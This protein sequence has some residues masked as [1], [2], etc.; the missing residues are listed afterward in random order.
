MN[1]NIKK[2]KKMRKLFLTLT[3]MLTL[4]AMA[5]NEPFLTKVYDFMPAPGQFVNTLPEF[6][7]GDTKADVLARVA[8][9]ICGYYEVEDGDT[10]MVYKPA[11]ISLGGFGGYVVM[12]FDHPVVNVKDDYDFQIFGNGFFAT[13]SS[14]GGSSE[15]GIVMVSYDA[16][17]NGIP[18]DPWYELAGSEYN[19]PKTQHNFTITYYKPDENKVKTPDPNSKYITDLTYVRWTSN[20]VNP[21]SVSGYVYKNSFHNQSYWPQWAEG[22]TLT[23]T[24]TKLCNN[25]FDTSGKGTYWVQYCK[26][27]GYVDNRTNYDPYSP[28]EGVDSALMNRGFKID[29]AV[30]ADGV[31]VHLPMVH[32]IKVYC[33]MNQYCGWL[34]ETSTEVAGGIDYHPQAAV[35]L[36]VKG[37]ADGNGTVD[38]SDVTMVINR[39]LGQ[40]LAGYNPLGFDLD[41]NGAIDV[42]DVTSLINVIL[43]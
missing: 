13:G 43:Q 1:N 6:N 33:A 3:V 24:G 38:V 32:F 39:I 17:G 25:A 16:N 18:D 37:D 8:E 2:Q 7:A 35:P 27:W 22:N 5:K 14:T 4:S 26:D 21:D 31:P 15:P 9:D 11:L 30:D 42:T 28:K 41:G 29:W 36:V 23:F 34:G 19:S 10:T 12:G 40:K 20:D